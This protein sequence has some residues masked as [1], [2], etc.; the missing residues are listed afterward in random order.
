MNGGFRLT[1][2]GLEEDLAV[3]YVGAAALAFGLLPLMDEGS[4]IVN[5]VS[6]T[7]RIGRV[8]KDLLQPDP[9]RFRR[10]SSYGSSKLALLLF[11]LELASRM[12]RRGIRVNAADPGVVDTG[13][14]TMAAGSIRWPINCSVRWSKTRGRERQ[15]HCCWLRRL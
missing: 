5:T 1:E 8:G 7:Y 2:D 15:R 12:A 10:F 11:T 3:N 4:R 6:C 14:L 9:H 13:M